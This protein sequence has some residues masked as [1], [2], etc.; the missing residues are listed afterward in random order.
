MAVDL[1]GFPKN[2]LSAG[3]SDPVSFSPSGH[4]R[5]GRG[6]GRLSFRHLNVGEQ[7]GDIGAGFQD[8]DGLIGV[9]RPMEV[10]PA[11]S[12]MSMARMR[13][14]ISSS[15]TRSTARRIA[16]IRGRNYRL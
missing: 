4:G 6:R 12:T 14:S 15:T 10:K 11:S 7:Q 2:W 13:S 16:R 9:N 1:S 3:I 5:R 8:G